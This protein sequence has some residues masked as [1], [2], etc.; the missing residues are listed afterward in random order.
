[1]K[2]L[3]KREA[4]FEFDDYLD[5]IYGY[6]EIGGL[7]YATSEA[8][9]KVDPDTYHKDLLTYV[10]ENDIIITDTKFIDNSSLLEGLDDIEE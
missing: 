10:L 9:K 1:M 5:L 8:I 2:Y 4:M 7:E 3:S 6:V